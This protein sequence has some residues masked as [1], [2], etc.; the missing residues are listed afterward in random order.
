[1]RGRESG[2]V[3]KGRALWALTTQTLYMGDKPS[4]AGAGQRDFF[5]GQRAVRHYNGD[6]SFLP[7]TASGLAA[8]A[9]TDICFLW[10]RCVAQPQ[11]QTE[12]C[13]LHTHDLR[14]NQWTQK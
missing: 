3:G 1:M 12:G 6:V 9:P 14:E 8:A 13:L 10:Q 2:E 5:L 11:Q 4:F 7:C